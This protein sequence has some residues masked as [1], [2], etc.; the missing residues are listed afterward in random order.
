MKTSI[1]KLFIL[2][3]ALLIAFFIGFS[4]SAAEEP[5]DSHT[6]SPFKEVLSNPTC[7]TSGSKA[8]KCIDCGAIK[9]GSTETISALG[10][11]WGGWSTT[12]EPT[13]TS[14]GEKKRYCGRSGCSASQS[15]SISALGHDMHNTSSA[16]CTS[17]STESCSRCDHQTHNTGALGHSWGGLCKN[18]RYVYSGWSLCTYVFEV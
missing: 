14:N 2:V 18:K 9:P 16:T 7:T 12:T 6:W 15:E 13:C 4:V 1:K 8:Y 3:E 10:H 17:P 11:S 5:G